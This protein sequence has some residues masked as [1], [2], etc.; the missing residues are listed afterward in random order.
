[1]QGVIP[2]LRPVGSWPD[3]QSPFGIHDLAGSVWEWT[4]TK[5]GERRI[6]K[7]GSFLMRAVAARASNRLA[8]DPDLIHPDT[9]FRCVKDRP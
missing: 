5:S 1:M 2:E 8:E 3:S 4:S 9:G 6:L 7:G